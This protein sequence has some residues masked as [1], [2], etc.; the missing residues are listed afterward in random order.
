MIGVR[1]F[2]SEAASVRAARE[3]VR[4]CLEETGADVESA[5][6]MTSELATN[7]IEHAHSNYE[8]EV[9]FVADAIRVEL[10]NDEP[11]VLPVIAEPDDARGRGLLLVEALASRGAPNRATTER[12]CGSSS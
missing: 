2:A 7:A 12:S 5:V 3:F 8:I 6:P 1:T 11:Q 4:D 9:R 10:R